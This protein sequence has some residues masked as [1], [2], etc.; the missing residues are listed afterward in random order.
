MDCNY[1]YEKILMYRMLYFKW[2]TVHFVWYLLVYYI[3]DRVVDRLLLP[4]FGSS[5]ILKQGLLFLYCLCV[6]WYVHFLKFRLLF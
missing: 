1:T 5:C 2:L 4:V 6:T 3:R